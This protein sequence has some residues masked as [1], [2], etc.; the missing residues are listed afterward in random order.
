MNVGVDQAR[1]D[2]LSVHPDFPCAPRHRD[3]VGWSYL[4]DVPLRHDDHRI[5]DERRAGAVI[6]CRAN[7]RHLTGAGVAAHDHQ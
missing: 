1:D 5:Q 7:V 6:E 2:P 4:L 3:D